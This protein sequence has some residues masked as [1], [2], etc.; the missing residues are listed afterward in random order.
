MCNQQN[1]DLSID[2]IKGV[3]IFLVV[4][5]HFISSFLLKDNS[6]FLRDPLYKAIYSFHMP[7]FVFISGWFFKNSTDN[8]FFCFIKK[9]FFR[10]IV[11]QISFVVLGIV[12]ILLFWN[13]FSY[14][15]CVNGTLS[16]K[17]IYHVVTFAWYLWCIFLCTLF[18][19]AVKRIT[20]NKL[21]YVILFACVIMWLLINYLPGPIFQNQQFARM[22]P[23]FFLG[24]QAKK[25][26]DRFETLKKKIFISCLFVCLGY[27]FV[28]FDPSATLP[29]YFVRI[30]LQLFPMIL[31]FII[32]RCLYAKNAIRPLFLFWSRDTLFIYVSH[33]FVLWLMEPFHLH[34][35]SGILVIDY[36]MYSLLSLVVCLFLG[37]LS[38][39]LRKKTLSRKIFL[40]EK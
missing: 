31:A 8:S 14:K 20:K 15:I 23:C 6:T 36:F 2:Y 22:L 40:G 35:S 29:G 27:F 5:A 4:W 1:R 19:N 13:T 10:L 12:V 16:I 7:L 26:E 24:M 30:P 17:Q 9:Q 34:F 25:H 37:L 39:L 33:I 38:Q 3:L 18:I 21:D 11:P 32:L 28:I